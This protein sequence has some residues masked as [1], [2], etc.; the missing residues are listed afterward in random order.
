MKIL[1]ALLTLFVLTASLAADE[2]YVTVYNQNLALVKQVRTM[3]ITRSNLPLRFTDVAAQ[4]IPTS[5]H[6][7]SLSGNKDFRVLEQNYEYDLV[8]GDKILQKYIDHDIQIITEKGEM[9][10]GTLLS[11]SGSSLV[12]KDADG[13]QIVP[14]NDKMRVSVKDL[15]EGLITRPTLIWDVAGVKTGREKLEVS[16]LTQGMD[17]HAEYVGVLNEKS[18]RMNLDAWVSVDNHSG[19]TFKNA[20]LKLVAGEIHRAPS[21]GPRI[22]AE[23]AMAKSAAAPQFKE[24]GFFEYH[25]YDLQRLTTLKDNQ[26]KQISLFPSTTV[27]CE[28]QFIYNARQDADKVFVKVVF[29]NKKEAGLGMPLPAGVFRVYKKDGQSLEFA[30]EDR[31]DHTPR[32]EEVRLTIGKAFDLRASRKVVASKRLS[33]HARR[34]TV[35]IELRN[36][37]EDQK[38]TIL[39][40]EA[41]AGPNW[42]IEQSNYKYVKKDISNIEFSVPV[43][44]NGKAKVRYTVI[45]SW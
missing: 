17:W 27:G 19:A 1:T 12:L 33:E 5:V 15:P 39:V 29:L 6:L 22:M 7:R 4:I 41:M 18:T 8:N 21:A 40:E 34:E 44:A 13:I 23:Y 2:N 25:I 28:K 38:V 35:E 42:E 24:R 10:R 32:N 14:W 16:Y 9:I 3:E 20:H 36:N 37:K 11:K 43:K 31:I 26:I 45:Y 30:G